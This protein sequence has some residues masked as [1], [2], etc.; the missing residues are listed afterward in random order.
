VRSLTLNGYI[1][2]VG[3][4]EGAAGAVIFAA[5]PSSSPAQDTALSRR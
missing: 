3:E 2:S 5:S 4:G 1:V